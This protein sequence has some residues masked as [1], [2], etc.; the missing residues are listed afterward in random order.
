MSLFAPR[1][2]RTLG[3][4]FAYKAFNDTVVLGGNVALDLLAN[5]I[6]V[7]SGPRRGREPRGRNRPR[8]SRL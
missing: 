6:Q 1:L 7:H 3:S 5:D 4:A 8:D 2:L